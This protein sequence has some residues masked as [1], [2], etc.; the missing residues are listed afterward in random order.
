MDNEV[1]DEKV[2]CELFGTI[3]KDCSF[4]SVGEVCILDP[5]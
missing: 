3:C 5:I 2:I 1:N 4:I